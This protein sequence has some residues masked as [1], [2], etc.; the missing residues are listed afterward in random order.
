MKRTCTLLV[1]ASLLLAACTKPEDK[2]VGHYDGKT[3]IPQET[4]DAMRAM[5]S[6]MGADPD[7][8]EARLTNSQISMAL[9]DDGTCT[10]IGES[11]G[12]SESMEGKW[13]LNKE[14]TQVTIQFT[15][16]EEKAADMGLPTGP[17]QDMV[18]N[19]SEDGKTLSLEDAQIGLTFGM[20]FTR[21]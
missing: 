4:I 13:T 7:E 11:D 12:R 19:V 9:R 8:V 5:A 17:N 10:L 2:F 3:A 16:L 1:I 18:L 21:K 15:G 14:G 20:T 6:S